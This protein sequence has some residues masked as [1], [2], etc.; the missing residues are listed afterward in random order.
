MIEL[1]KDTYDTYQNDR[2]GK[3]ER[4][5]NRLF[6]FAAGALLISAFSDRSDG[7]IFNMMVTGLTILTGF[8]FTALFSDH[9]MADVGLPAPKNETDRND[10][11][12]LRR[13]A[14]N[15]HIRSRYFIMLSIIDVCLLI[16]LATNLAVPQFL[17][18]MAM[19]LIDDTRADFKSI[20]QT[21]SEA[22]IWAQNLSTFVAIVIFLECLFTFYRLAETIIAMVSRRRAYLRQ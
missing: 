12:V 2:E 16:V 9:S 14:D 18:E 7:A 6:L 1:I 22:M 10:V 20:S 13:L 17:T 5:W 11:K 19:A 4:H 15:F 3:R 8:T 21:L